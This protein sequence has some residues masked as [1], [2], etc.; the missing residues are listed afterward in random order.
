[1]LAI[2]SRATMICNLSG[3][4]ILFSG[5]SFSFEA[6]GAYRLRGDV[7]EVVRE[8]FF[9]H[10]GGRRIDPEQDVL[11]PFLRRVTES[12]RAIK[13]E[14][15]IFAELDPFRG[16]MGASFPP[17]MPE[18]TVNASHWYCLVTL[19][20]KTFMYPVGID[21][22]TGNALHGDEDIEAYYAAQL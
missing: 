18:R 14:W 10:V 15:M 4:C 21:P 19:M 11:R 6:A 20:T 22:F 16:L 17:G 2:V 8:E 7:T 13:P 9:R 1:M 5:A 12:V 3:V